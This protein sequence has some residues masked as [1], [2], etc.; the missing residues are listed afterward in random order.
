M[1]N[2]IVKLIIELENRV[3]AQLKE[4][5]AQMEQVQ[6]AAQQAQNAMRQFDSSSMDKA[7]NSANQLDKELTEV[8]NRTNSTK[9]A[10]NSI[11]PNTINQLSNSA[12]LLTTSMDTSMNSAYRLNASI[13]TI[14]SGNLLTASYSA[15]RLS[16]S[17]NSS[18]N[19][20]RSLSSSLKQAS[21]SALSLS[22]GINSITGYT[23]TATS[24]SAAQLDMALDRARTSVYSTDAALDLIDGSG[25]SR[26][27]A[28]AELL[29]AILLVLIGILQQ[30][31][32]LL[33][34][35]TTGLDNV[36]R[37]IREAQLALEGLRTSSQK[38]GTGFGGLGNGA[39]T[40]GG[41]LGFLRTAASMTVG[42]I[43]F[44]LVNSMVQGARESINAAASFERFGQRL[45]MTEG[46]LQQF[47]GA[48]DKMQD[49]FRKVDMN[50]VGAAALEMGVKLKIPKA[51]MEELTKT[52]AVMSSAFVKEGRTQEDAI[53]AVSDAMDGQFRR[54]QEIG[55]S[56]DMLMKNGWDGDI[57]NKTGL[58]QA[59]NETLSDMGFEQSA[60]EI[61]TLDDA[62][63]A[64]TVTGSKLIQSILVPIT[65]IIITV[66][67][68][69]TW[70]VEALQSAWSSM[71]DWAKAAVT[72][73]VLST[74][75]V[76]LGIVILGSVIPAIA[77]SA[78]SFVTYIAG[79]LGV[80]I[81]NMGLAASFLA[82]AGAIL[83][84]PLTWVVV[85]LVA[86]AVAIYEVGK[87]FGWWKD[88]GTMLEAIKNNIGRL[89]D[90]FIN[91]PDVK[92]TIK[93][94]QD[95]W[96]DLNESLKPIVDW[97]KGI[98]DEIFPESAKGK[99]DGTR[100]VIDAIGAVFESFK[101]RVQLA[102]NI[103]TIIWDVFNGIASLLRGDFTGALSFFTDAWNVLLE[104][105]SP[106]AEFLES[107]L[108]PAFESFFATL[109][110]DGGNPVELINQGFLTLMETLGPVLD[111]LLIG[112]V[113]AWQLVHDIV[114][115]L[116]NLFMQLTTIFN[117]LITGQISLQQA[118]A[119]AW[120][121]IQSTISTILSNVINRVV[122]WAQSMWNNAV[123]TGRNF[124]TGVVQF[125]QQLPDKTKMYLLAVAAIVI[126]AGA[127][128][129]IN[130]KTKASQVV[131]GVMSW[132]KQLPQ[133]VYLELLNIGSRILSAGSQ[134][135]ENAKQIGKKIVD[136]M[137]SSMGIH[138][139]GII[140]E[141][142]V[143]EF[144]NMLQRVKDKGKSA[145]EAGKNVGKNI[146]N[147][148]NTADVE[149]AL[150]NI[151]TTITTPVTTNTEVETDSANVDLS[152]NNS[153]TEE[154]G[155]Q[156]NGLVEEVSL[157]S[158]SITASNNMIGTSFSTLTAGIA[159]NAGAIQMRVAGVVT[160]FQTTRNG[161]TTALTSMSNSNT[162]AW[163]NIKSTTTQ[164]LNQVRNS[165]IDVTNK[166]TNA[167][168]V[169][170]DN[171]VSAAGSIQ[172][173][174]YNKFSSLHRS[175]ASFYNQLANAH[176]SSGLPAGPATNSTR[177]LIGGRTLPG[178]SINFGKST[179]GTIASYAAGGL[180]QGKG[181]VIDTNSKV[182]H[183]QNNK[184][185]SWLNLLD[186]NL[187]TSVINDL[188][189]VNGC[190]NPN[191]CFAG[192]P[193][194]NVNKIMNTAYKWR[195][196]DPWFLGI[197]IPSDYHVEDFRD[198][199]QPQLNPGNF[200]N[201]LRKILTARGFQ[202]PGTYE[203]YYN[204]RYS[205]Q[206]VWDQVRCN[207]FDGAE[208][209]IEI[210]S[211]LGLSGH[212]IHGSWNGI[213]HVAA[214]VNGQIYDMTQFQKRGGI[215][216]G[217]SGVSFGSAS[218]GGSSKDV[219]GII[220]DGIYNIIDL[221]KTNQNAYFQNIEHNRN[222]TTADNLVSYTSDDVHLTI[223]HNLNVTV[224]GEDI[225]EKSIITTL[226]EVITDSKL[227]DRIAEALIKR[228]NRIKRMRG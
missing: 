59:M 198:G 165:T 169:M 80:E 109:Q 20:T 101:V 133:K 35:H 27:T 127:L 48:V 36:T 26:T 213:G 170:K 10:L 5:Q 123:N 78:T 19:S 154:T 168:G 99:V 55:I 9:T 146:V 191:T 7:K 186:Y 6:K 22:R 132:I 24:S 211:M 85:A 201:L 116:F 49:S 177:G 131:S 82:V 206:Q 151:S 221:M 65:P 28:S 75:L 162:R 166:M 83:A 141:K 125:I 45:G 144:F 217:G 117:Q 160:S 88:V 34:F 18:N 137:L 107:T 97:L 60:Q 62:W 227:I 139:P 29:K 214:M 195:I 138:S 188:A 74:A 183:P 215:F 54:L 202:N 126:A 111:F 187:P 38:T 104:G 57:N 225:D 72:I 79:A 106:I 98:W 212:M 100:A 108:G 25:F 73:G 120:A 208:M 67:E 176:F 8:T 119:W 157:A 134:L 21:S 121:A 102:I 2:N 185:K 94:I 171:I 128:W 143:L 197:Q 68:M 219:F 205:N 91:H 4:I 192:I 40:A 178:G 53:L 70:M 69:I 63:A 155:D 150:N 42:M 33:N 149:N 89:W 200:E 92:A 39:K 209:I 16:S 181:R 96:S 163:N 142:V 226:K 207:C 218:P 194:T 50:A 15:T 93:A 216:R 37:D 118:I 87:A 47:H 228:D 167:W 189:R 161:V 103:L 184:S 179:K 122:S 31:N 180:G 148:F 12:K 199:K 110:G 224:E 44:D 164:N 13:N 204:S 158:E 220:T 11:N 222:N 124:C 112:F 130:A 203:F 135:V 173:Q 76:G 77:A 30:V 175:I 86:I 56:Q 41:G 182:K 81:A 14:N 140:Q 46:E 95:A 193:D 66:V 84:N 145:Y 210:A 129:V 17:M 32:S 190:V 174:S 3:K 61:V 71:P 115:P 114:T 136:G 64:L 43:G 147:G 23:L 52:T 196:A 58:L 1:S 153:G 172:T 159:L 223:D 156:Y 90:A 152:N 105:L 113:P 51:S